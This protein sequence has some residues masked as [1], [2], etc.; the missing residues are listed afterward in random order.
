MLGP[1]DVSNQLIAS[2]ITC[3]VIGLK[4]KKKCYSLE[5]KIKEHTD[6]NLQGRTFD[7]PFLQWK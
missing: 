6:L 2:Y 5:F 1:F 4:I 7:S 3:N